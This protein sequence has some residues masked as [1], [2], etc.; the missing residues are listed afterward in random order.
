VDSTYSRSPGFQHFN[1][2]SR[3]VSFL[4]SLQADPTPSTPAIHS[5][6]IYNTSSIVRPSKF[7]GYYSSTKRNISKTQNSDH[8]VYL[9]VVYDSRDERRLFHKT[10]FI[11]PSSNGQSVIREVWTIFF[12]II[13]INSFFN[14]LNKQCFCMATLTE[15]FPC[16]FLSCKANAKVKPA[17]TGHGPHS[18]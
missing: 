15:V 4:Q 7:S 17:K 16:F 8:A 18:S 2:L 10:E 3:D 9:S 6:I 1:Q 5:Y 11:V 14:Q 12:N 13:S